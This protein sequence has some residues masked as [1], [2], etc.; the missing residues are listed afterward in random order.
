LPESRDAVAQLTWPGDNSPADKSENT[1]NRQDQEI[2][3]HAVCDE[4]TDEPPIVI[5]GQCR[6]AIH[7]QIDMANMTAT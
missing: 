7:P 3:S 5:T 1:A 2:K 6:A 4:Q